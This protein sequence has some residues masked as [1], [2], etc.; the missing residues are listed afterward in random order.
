MRQHC[1]GCGDD[2][3]GSGGSGDD[4]IALSKGTAR[5]HRPAAAKLYAKQ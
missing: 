2:G 4:I 3:G 1:S 5:L